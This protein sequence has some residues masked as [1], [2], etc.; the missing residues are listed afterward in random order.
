MPVTRQN[1]EDLPSTPG[2]YIMRD[3]TGK[4]IYVG[5]AVVLKT[6]SDSILII[7]RSCQKCRQWWIMSTDS[8]ILSRSR[9]RCFVSR[10]KSC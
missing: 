1:L 10:S 4:V 9:K 8:S 2:V 7:L 3:V 6:E 5:K